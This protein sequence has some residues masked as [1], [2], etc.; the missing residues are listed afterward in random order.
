[1]WEYLE[2]TA[3]IGVRA[4]GSSV[5]EVFTD[6]ANGLLHYMADIEPFPSEVEVDVEC[7]AESWDDLL[8]E[9]LNR[10]LLESSVKR[11]VFKEIRIEE[12]AE[13][14]LRAKVIGGKIKNSLNHALKNE[15]KA[16]TYYQLSIIFDNDRV[17][18][19]CYFDV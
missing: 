12:V 2:H 17:I 6:M 18:A 3:D 14:H 16:A 10:L 5:S 19:Q 15:V 8:V 11:V 7:D 4:E 13:T 9:F 1:M